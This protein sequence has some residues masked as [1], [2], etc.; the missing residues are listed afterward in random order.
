M[1]RMVFEC[2]KWTEET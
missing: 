2:E 1:R